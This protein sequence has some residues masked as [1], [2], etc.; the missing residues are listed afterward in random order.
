MASLPVDDLLNGAVDDLGRLLRGPVD[1]P[2]GA[3]RR[4]LG[5]RVNILSKDPLLSRV[6]SEV[7]LVFISFVA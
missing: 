4:R 5:R 2:L 3:L 1:D 7:L 6:Y